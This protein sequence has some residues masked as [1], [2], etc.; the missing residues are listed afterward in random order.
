M[1]RASWCVLGLAAG[2]RRALPSPRDRNECLTPDFKS[3]ST[4][5]APSHRASI[6][7]VL[8][9]CS[10][11]RSFQQPSSALLS[12]ITGRRLTLVHSAVPPS[13]CASSA[14]AFIILHL[15]S[16]TTDDLPSCPLVSSNPCDCPDNSSALSRTLLP[17]FCARPRPNLDDLPTHRGSTCP[18]FHP[19]AL[20]SCPNRTMI[21][22]HVQS[23]N[24]A[25]CSWRTHGEVREN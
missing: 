17:S 13:F 18:A 22:F 8:N 6:T 16:H 11:N 9:R 10:R 15:P 21:I 4:K 24:G 2:L 14:H 7:R 5:T 12:M 3:S 20:V 1:R 23:R 19:V 25:S